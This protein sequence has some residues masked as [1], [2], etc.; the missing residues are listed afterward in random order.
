ML[1]IVN[2]TN[3]ALE[4]SNLNRTI[5]GEILKFFCILIL[6]LRFNVSKR[7]EL[8]ADFSRFSHIPL[9]EFGEIMENRRFMQIRRLIVFS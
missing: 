2:W 6:M 1:Y 3:E 5:K 8:W 4:Q 9:P 7:R